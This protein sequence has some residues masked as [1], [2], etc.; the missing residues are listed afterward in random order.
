MA[1]TKTK[2]WQGKSVPELKQLIGERASKLRGFRFA[3]AGSKI[4]NVKE[5]KKLRREISQLLTALSVTSK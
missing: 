1:Q 2:I 3:V 5:A 4:T